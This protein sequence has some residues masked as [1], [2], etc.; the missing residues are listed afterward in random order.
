ME[1]L[2]DK[3][4]GQIITLLVILGCIVWFLISA[5]NNSDR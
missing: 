2:D 3:L 1:P 5:W 4:F